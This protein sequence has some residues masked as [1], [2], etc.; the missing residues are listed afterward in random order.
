MRVVTLRD[1]SAP[2]S[3]VRPPAWARVLGKSLF[4]STLVRAEILD[5][6]GQT[7]HDYRFDEGRIVGVKATTMTL[8]ERDGT[9]QVIPI[10]S[11]TVVSMGSQ[12]VDQSAI[13]KGLSALTIREGDGP[14]EQ[15]MLAT[16]PF[17]VRK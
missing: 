2:A 16:G 17:V 12:P 13:V 8:L 3:Q 9:R 11:T 5:F 6:V 1:G 10:S 14:A 4:G 7:V 15:V